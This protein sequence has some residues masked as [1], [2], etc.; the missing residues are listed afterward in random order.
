MTSIS[1]NLQTSFPISIIDYFSYTPFM[2]KN[3]KLLYTDTIAVA[4]GGFAFLGMVLL[5]YRQLDFALVEGNLWLRFARSEVVLYASMTI[6]FSFF[7]AMQAYKLR[8]FGA[9][10]KKKSVGWWIGWLLWIVTVWCPACSITLAS[11]LWLSAFVLILPF[12]WLEIKVVAIFLLLR[13]DYTML[14]DLAI[15]KKR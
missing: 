7:V 5:Q 2:L 9:V 13:V 12:K 1:H 14:R 3:I 4:R 6:L 11:F 8:Q 10:S 15:C